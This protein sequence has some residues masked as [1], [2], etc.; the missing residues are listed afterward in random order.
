MNFTHNVCLLSP[1]RAQKVERLLLAMKIP[2]YLCLEV[3]KVNNEPV[4]DNYLTTES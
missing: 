2:C 4:E 3:N 1:L